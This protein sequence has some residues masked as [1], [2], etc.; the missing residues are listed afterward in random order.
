MGHS[1]DDRFQITCSYCGFLASE[2]TLKDA[3]SSA[4]LAELRHNAEYEH[5]EIFDL[6]AHT[7]KPELYNSSG[8]VITVKG[9]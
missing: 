5:I 7:G 8:E 1:P 4:N 3:I 2:R 6:M 9:E